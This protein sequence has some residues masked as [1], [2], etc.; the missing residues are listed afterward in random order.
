MRP[1]KNQRKPSAAD[2]RAG[3]GGAVYVDGTSATS[4]TFVNITR[5]RMVTNTAALTASSGVGGGLYLSGG[6]ASMNNN[7]FVGNQAAGYGGAMAYDH[8]C[9]NFSS[10]PGKAFV[11]R[12]L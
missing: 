2:C 8:Q 5:S 3:S 11:L 1:P 9:F 6:V 10:V 7:S 12:V 4:V